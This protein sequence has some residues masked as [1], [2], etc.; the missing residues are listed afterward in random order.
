MKNNNITDISP[1]ANL[2]NLER[3]ELQNNRITDITPLESLTYLE[4]LDTRNNPIF[5]ADSPVVDIPD[6]NLR[7][8]IRETLKLPDGVPITRTFMRQLTGLDAGGSGIFDLT[9]L[10]HATS[11]TF[12]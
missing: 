11:L 9:G 4:H 7:T 5:D 2:V 10:E 12:S 1:L 8:A 6:P 3:L